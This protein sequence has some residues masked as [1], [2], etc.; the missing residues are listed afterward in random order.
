M[1]TTKSQYTLP[2]I[3][4]KLA[5]QATR[6]GGEEPVPDP[7]VRKTSE[8]DRALRDPS[9]QILRER[10]LSLL[11]RAKLHEGHP[12]TRLPSVP[13]IG[14]ILALVLFSESHDR[15][16]FPRVPAVV[17]SC[18]RVQGAPAATGNRLGTSG[19]KIGT[20]H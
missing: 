4:K 5:D 17:S 10:E 7:S 16:R 2:E 12:F 6:E 11:R 20:G 19:K 8:G 1:Q 15:T 9:A 3:G 13:G 14:H 18:R